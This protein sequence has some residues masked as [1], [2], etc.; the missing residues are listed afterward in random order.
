MPDGIAPLRLLC[1]PELYC[2]LVWKDVLPEMLQGIEIT[3]DNTFDFCVVMNLRIAKNV[4]CGT[5]L[6]QKGSRLL[7]GNR[8]KTDI[9]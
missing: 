8:L 6:L 3:H 7:S 2:I 1:R 5:V 9:P 4:L